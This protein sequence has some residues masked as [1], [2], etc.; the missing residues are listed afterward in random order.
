MIE[1]LNFC[2]RYGVE[3]TISYDSVADGLKIKAR[4]TGK[5]KYHSMTIPKTELDNLAIP[6][7]MLTQIIGNIIVRELALDKT[8]TE[9]AD[10][11]KEEKND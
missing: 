6:I 2:K 4:Q 9:E 8:Q 10:H 1:V 3:I 11:D 7:T 5:L